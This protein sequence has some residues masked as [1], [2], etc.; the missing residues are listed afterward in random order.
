ML[1][2]KKGA[3]MHKISA[4]TLQIGEILSACAPNQL[5]LN[6]LR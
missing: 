2:R 3:L 1:H 4:I 5:I 6:G